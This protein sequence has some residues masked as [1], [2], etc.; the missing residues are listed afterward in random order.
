M[1]MRVRSQAKCEATSPLTS[2]LPVPVLC[3]LSAMKRTSIFSELGV[4]CARL[5]SDF[6]SRQDAKLAK[7]SATQPFF[8]RGP[9]LY[10]CELGALCAFA[11]GKF[12]SVFSHQVRLDRPCVL[13]ARAHDTAKSQM[14]R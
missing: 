8:L 5:S 11:G 4:L 12:F 2:N 13:L 9:N 6:F 3:S 1:L 7:A 10:F 14:T